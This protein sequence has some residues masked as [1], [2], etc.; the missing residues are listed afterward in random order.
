MDTVALKGKLAEFLRKYKYVLLVLLAGIVL[1][2]LPGKEDTG[3]DHVPIADVP[4]SQQQNSLDK[5]LEA[6]LSAIDGAGMV[7]VLLTIESGEKTLYQYD[8]QTAAGENGSTKKDT[9]IIT[10]GD[11]GQSGL[12]QQIDPP[13]YQGA[14]VLCQGADSA[15]VRLCIIE[16]VSKLT[17]LGTDR[18]CVLKMK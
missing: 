1:M 12:I 16:A 18:I 13:R 6:V 10:N 17:G 2:L 3:Q 5:Q 9:V 7:Q 14:V 8:E 11:R 4:T 15:Y